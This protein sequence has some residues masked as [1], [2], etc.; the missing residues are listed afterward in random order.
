MIAVASGTTTAQALED[1]GADLVLPDLTDVTRLVDAIGALTT[2]IS[3]A[4]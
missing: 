1:A 2:T 3:R 4:D